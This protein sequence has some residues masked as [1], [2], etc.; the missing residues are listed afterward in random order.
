MREHLK[1]PLAALALAALGAALRRGQMD[2]AF[3]GELDLSIPGAP[4]SVAMAAFFVLAAA[5][6]T[7]LAVGARVR[8][9]SESRLSQWDLA[10][11]APRDA[12][13][14]ALM[15]L[16]ALLTLTSIPFLFQEAVQMS[17]VR[18][19]TGR[20]DSPLLQIVLAL[21]AIPGGLGLAMSAGISC[22]ASGKG[23]EN[24]A[25]LL[26]LLLCCVWLLE[27]YRS[28]A[29]DPV[30]W[31][32]VPLLL[33]VAM[34]LLFQMEGAGMAFTAKGHPRRLLWLAGMTVAASG[35]ALGGLPRPGML[36]LL[37]GQAL[38]AL[39]ALWVLPGNLSDPFEDD[40]FGPQARLAPEGGGESVPDEPHEKEEDTN[41]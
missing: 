3:E 33:A 37:G 16:G 1:W 31:D 20:G 19:E 22:R 36:L 32:Y 34:A 23:R 39:G 5:T 41:G 28:N 6:F 12:V 15:A 4:A 8:D 35:A 13:Y 21:C 24:S 26:P 10:F 11:A 9:T 7:L 17:A 27:A 40:V 29:A 18:Q 14:L 38:C 25:L 30:L 2:T